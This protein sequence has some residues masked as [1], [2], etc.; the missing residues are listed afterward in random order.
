[1]EIPS[2]SVRMVNI[3][4]QST[5][6]SEDIGKGVPPAGGREM[7]VATVELCVEMPQKD[8]NKLTPRST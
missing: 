5:E 4:K 1:M 8:E 2:S 6:A 7:G 3:S